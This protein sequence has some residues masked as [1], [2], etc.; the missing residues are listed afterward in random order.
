MKPFFTIISTL[1]LPAVLVAQESA[2]PVDVNSP[3]KAAQPTII[4][5][6]QPEKA[7]MGAYQKKLTEEE[8]D[9]RFLMDLQVADRVK[10]AQTADI[11]RSNQE[12][13]S[14]A[15]LEY[16]N[17]LLGQQNAKELAKANLTLPPITASQNPYTAYQN[18]PSGAGRVVPGELPTAATGN[19]AEKGVL[20]DAAGEDGP[21]VA[22]AKGLGYIPKGTIIDIR[23][24]TRVNT[25]IPGPVIGEVVYDV[26]DT[27]MKC[28]VIPRGTKA[29]GAASQMGSDTDA[30]G[31]VTFDTFIAP[32]GREI[33]IAVPVLTASRI[34]ITGIPGK[35]DYH[36]GRIFGSSLALAVLTGFTGSSTAPAG[37]NPTMT[38]GDVIRQNINTQ[39]NTI[40]NSLLSR[41]TGIKPDITLEEGTISKVI[42]MQHM[43]LKPYQKI[44]R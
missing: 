20:D 38:Q 6:T 23:L 5:P 37:S 4:L 30:G 2:P 10:S 9:A 39:V 13:A 34:G 19:V 11:I 1:V 24:Y 21:A 26:W 25:S 35:V 31:K 44:Y 8:R 18:V 22:R 16:Y 42:I 33:P 27:D 15:L 28:I 43:L 40:G 36:W 7:P 17:V 32:S 29:M 41:F 14:A 12:K 3:Y